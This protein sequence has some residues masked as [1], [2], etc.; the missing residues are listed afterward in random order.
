MA[1]VDVES[2]RVRDLIRFLIKHGFEEKEINRV[3]DKQV[4][5]TM[6]YKVINDAELDK[7][8]KFMVEWIYNWGSKIGGGILILLLSLFLRKPLQDFILSQFGSLKLSYKMM[9]SSLKHSRYLACLGLILVFLL[10]FINW[11]LKTSVM[12]SWFS[13]MLLP[14]AISYQFRQYF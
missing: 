7:N 14:E 6:V 2:M 3:L 13:N 11:W 8:M 9:K 10:D 4:L 12:L 1:V 5:K